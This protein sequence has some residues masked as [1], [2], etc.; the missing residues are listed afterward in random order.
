MLQQVNKLDLVKAVLIREDL[1]D[2]EV[3]ACITAILEQPKN[4][5]AS[6]KEIQDLREWARE[7]TKIGK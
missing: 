4:A 7:N 1:T 3:R 6:K 2:I 5:I